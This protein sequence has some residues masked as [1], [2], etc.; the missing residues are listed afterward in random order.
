[1]NRNVL[2]LV[3]KCYLMTSIAVITLINSF[4]CYTVLGTD[5]IMPLS[6]MGNSVLPVTRSFVKSLD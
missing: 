3:C 6:Q 1:M 5:F 2:K 4:V